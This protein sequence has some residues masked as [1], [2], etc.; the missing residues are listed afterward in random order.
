MLPGGQKVEKDGR[1]P[2]NT[3]W[4]P[5]FFSV[6]PV[7][8]CGFDRVAHIARPDERGG[9]GGQRPGARVSGG[10]GRKAKTPLLAKL[11]F[12]FLIGSQCMGDPG[13]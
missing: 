9:R 7:C 6:H 13:F 12:F 5:G 1:N 8:E 4:I 11:D 2:E 3:R 10:P